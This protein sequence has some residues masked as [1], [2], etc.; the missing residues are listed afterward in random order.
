MN[1]TKY[2][3][4]PNEVYAFPKSVMQGIAYIQDRMK[5]QDL[6][7]KPGYGVQRVFQELKTLLN[8]EGWLLTK[9]VDNNWKIEPKK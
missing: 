2:F 1:E 7:F 5:H 9:D 6:E 3:Q 8:D 4:S